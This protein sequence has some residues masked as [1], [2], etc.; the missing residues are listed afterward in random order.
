MAFSASISSL[1]GRASSIGG[2]LKM[3][4]HTFSA[5]SGDLSGTVTSKNL[6]TVYHCILDGVVSTAAPT[7]SGKVA[8]LAFADPGATVYGTLLLIGV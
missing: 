1:E 5:A 3:E 8:T 4:I 7:F 2:P 6:H